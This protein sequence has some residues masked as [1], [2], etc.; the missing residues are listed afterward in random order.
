MMAQGQCIEKLE[1]KDR[2][3]D[4]SDRLLYLPHKLVL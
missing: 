2:Q 4:K 3:T 1:R